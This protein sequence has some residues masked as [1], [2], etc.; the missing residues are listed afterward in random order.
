MNTKEL[1]RIATWARSICHRTFGP[2]EGE[3]VFRSLPAMR[4]LEAWSS[5]TLIFA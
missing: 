5:K 4:V 3:R 2:E 1:Q